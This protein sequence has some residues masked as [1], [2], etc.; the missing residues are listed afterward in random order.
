MFNYL[1]LTSRK[2]KNL[3]KD[4]LHYVGIS[5]LNGVHMYELLLDKFPKDKNL[6]EELKH[7]SFRIEYQYPWMHFSPYSFQKTKNIFDPNGYKKCTT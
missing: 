1:I 4:Y 7:I 3:D 2:S 6:A 5:V